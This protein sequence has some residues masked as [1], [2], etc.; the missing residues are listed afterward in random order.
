MDETQLNSPFN[1]KQK[2]VKTKLKPLFLPAEIKN[3]LKTESPFC[4]HTLSEK[5]YVEGSEHLEDSKMT[6]FF[7]D[8]SRD[9]FLILK[10]KQRNLN[11]RL[12]NLSF[13]D[14]ESKLLHRILEQRE[15]SSKGKAILFL[16]I[17]PIINP[18][19]I[20]LLE[21]E[22]DFNL[23]LINLTQT[24]PQIHLTQL[25]LTYGLSRK[26]VFITSII[27]SNFILSYDLGLN[28]SVI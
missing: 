2:T 6:I 1:Q 13:I 22:S 25:V 23:K 21:I 5:I 28:Y 10:L 16:N 8:N 7:L 15:L 11:F 19:S 20:F 12:K 26:N 17:C 24:P 9:I 18:D 27:E 4:T 14:K 3:F